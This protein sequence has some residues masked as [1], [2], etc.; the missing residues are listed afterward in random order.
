MII[1]FENVSFKYVTTPI[2][3]KVDFVVNEKEKWGIVGIN[4]SGKSTFLQLLSQTIKPDAGNITYLNKY[5]ISYCPQNDSFNEEDTILQ[6]ITKAIAKD[7]IEDYQIKNILN[8]FNLTDHNQPIST[9]S[10]GQRKRLALAISLITPADLYLLDEPTN[11]LDQEMILWLEDFLTNLNKAIVMV[12]HDRYF[13]NRITNHIVEID[14]GHLYTYQGNYAYYLEQREIRYQQAQTSERKRQNFL[15]KEIEWV[16]AG[17]QARSTKSKARLDHYYEVYNQQTLTSKQTLSLDSA[18]TYLGKKI[19]EVKDISKSFDD[20]TLFSNISFTLLRD[21]RIGIIGD[22]GCGKTT[23]IKVITKQ[24]QP[25]CGTVE[26]GDTVK[27]GYLAQNNAIMDPNMRVIDYLKQF[28]ETVQTAHNETIT[29]SAM[30]DNFLFDT[31][32]Q[33][34]PISKCSGGEKRRLYLCSILISAPN[35]LIL[36]EPTNDLDTDT[37]TILENYLEDFNG[38]VISVSHDRYFLDKTCDKIFAFEDGNINTY[39]CSYSEYISQ[40]KQVQ[41]EKEETKPKQERTCNLITMT[42]KE[43][44]Q[45]EKLTNSLPILEDEIKQLEQQLNTISDYQKIKEISNILES[46][47]NQHDLD[48]LEWLSLSEKYE[49][50][51]AQN[52]KTQN[53]ESFN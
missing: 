1:S 44:N 16:K 51:L 36:D 2:F 32:Q 30:L 15:K 38:A 8:R 18:S 14:H 53:K 23:F 35:I 12:T 41:K 22:N 31:D 7:H 37:L 45:L 46:K 5:K 29:A 28:G 9:C 20:K 50:V 40:R 47:R 13:L 11:H 26:I 3:D 6:T 25:S 17:V 39:I 21:D 34:N 33:Y 19:I 42:S 4:G 24:L 52:K 10:G 43:K 27:I 48:E 49:Q